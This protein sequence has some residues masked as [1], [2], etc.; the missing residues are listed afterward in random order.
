MTE[1]LSCL[2]PEDLALLLS[3]PPVLS[4]SRLGRQALGH[5]LS[6]LLELQGYRVHDG[7][8]SQFYKRESDFIQQNGNVTGRPFLRE[9]TFNRVLIEIGAHSKN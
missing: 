9:C 3:A 1:C 5:T 4:V 6:I 8:A 7:P 2:S